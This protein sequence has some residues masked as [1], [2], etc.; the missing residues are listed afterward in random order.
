MIQKTLIVV[1]AQTGAETRLR[2]TE[3]TTPSDI[4]A[5]LGLNDYHLARV[6]DRQVLPADR[7]VSPAV[8]DGERLFA[9]MPMEVGGQE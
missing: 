6:R 7:D 4:V 9:F 1:N 5:H 3:G 8:Q 2:A